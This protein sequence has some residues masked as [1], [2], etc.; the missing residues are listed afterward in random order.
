MEMLDKFFYNFFETLDKFY[1]FLE[2][3]SGK[4]NVWVWHKRVKYLDKK[5]KKDGF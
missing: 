4:L 1:S 3:Y 5:R 2:K